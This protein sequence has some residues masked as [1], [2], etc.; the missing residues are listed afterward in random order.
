MLKNTAR[1][2][3][4]SAL[5]A[6]TLSASACGSA[7][8][9]NEHIFKDFDVAASLGIEFPSEAFDFGELSETAPYIESKSPNDI[10][11]SPRSFK[12]RVTDKMRI[13]KKIGDTSSV[14]TIYQNE[15]VELVETDDPDW[16]LV[17][18]ASGS[19]LGYTNEGFLH[20]IDESCGIFGELPI[21]YG[22][23]RTNS[24]TYVDAYSHLVDI[25]KYLNC[26][27]STDPS[28]D[29]VDISQYDVKV[30][31]KLSTSETSIN[32]PFY[33]RNLCMF[34][35]DTLQKL[36][37]AIE[38]FRRDGYTIVIY[39]AYRPTS[40]QQQWFDVV[41]VHKWVADP[42]RGMGGV[43]DRGTAID[44]SLI[45]K[46]GNELEMPTPMHTFTEASARASEE[47]SDEARKNMNYM[48][49]VMVSCGFTYINSEWWHFQD[50]NTQY[51]LPT[52]HPIDEI[53]LVPSEE[54]N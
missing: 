45:D 28:N 53:P 44:M 10:S 49:N 9:V 50:V 7:Y 27:F 29:G 51:Y 16:V 47:M 48:T 24:N 35:Y 33:S 37:K 22:K 18:S 54:L 43:H 5:L 3:K 17:K 30:S 19:E 40:V 8:Y 42:S 39:D 15:V 1:I 6:C 32:Q 20:A 36:I 13:Y 34:Q 23:A 11:S 2:A 4:L 46:D 14:R 26:Y 21:E 31:M 25:S 41:K 38:I 12:M 52:D